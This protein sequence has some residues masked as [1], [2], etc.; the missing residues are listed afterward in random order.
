[1]APLMAAT[2]YA[3][4]GWI[5]AARDALDRAVKGPAWEAAVEQRLFVEALLDTFEGERTASM[6]KADAL[7]RMPMP[8]AGP[9]ARARVARLRRGIAAMARAFA[10][11]AKHADEKWLRAAAVTS[12]LIHWAMRYA[13]AVVAIDRGNKTRAHKLLEGAPEWPEQSAFRSFHEQLADQI[14]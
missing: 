4:Y 6:E 10:H 9:F 7:E 8:P 2:A 13:A 1:M 3:A 5:D 11:S 14:A 12:P